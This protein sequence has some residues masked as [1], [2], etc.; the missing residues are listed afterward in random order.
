MQC[1]TVLTAMTPALEAGDGR[2]P[3]VLGPWQG[4]KMTAVCFATVLELKEFWPD[5]GNSA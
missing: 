4:L 5:V 2:D 3:E 1:G